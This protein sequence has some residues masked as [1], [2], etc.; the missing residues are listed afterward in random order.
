MC[1]YLKHDESCLDLQ[2]EGEI[3]G[4]TLLG[5]MVVRKRGQPAVTPLGLA[6]V[7]IKC[8]EPLLT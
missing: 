5:N 7:G 8:C 6:A 4:E 1:Q 3:V 2:I